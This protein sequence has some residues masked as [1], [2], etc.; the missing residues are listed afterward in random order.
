MAWTNLL[1]LLLI[2]AGHTELVVMLINRI[3]ALPIPRPKLHR[4]RTVADVLVLSFPIALLWFVGIQGGS[5]SVVPGPVFPLC[6][7]SISPCAVADSWRCFRRCFAGACAA[8]PPCKY[9]TSAGPSTS[10]NGWATNRWEKKGTTIWRFFRKTKLFP[11]RSPI[12]L[13]FAASTPGMA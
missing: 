5:S 9:Q 13:R 6:G 12:T 4:F 1:I 10:P 7:W 11:C 3:D 8:F 2:V